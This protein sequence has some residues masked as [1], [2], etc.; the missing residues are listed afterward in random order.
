MPLELHPSGL[1]VTV[2]L[3]PNARKSGFNGLMETA[4]GKTALKISVNVPPE[5]GKANKALIAFLAKSWKLPKS[6]ISLLSGTTNRLKTLLVNGD[7]PALMER[8]TP[9]LPPDAAV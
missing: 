2:R 7:G 9:L 4:D 3:T 5:D 8:I 6:S 1:K